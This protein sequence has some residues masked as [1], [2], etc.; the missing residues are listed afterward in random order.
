[1]FKCRYSIHNKQILVDST[2]QQFRQVRSEEDFTPTYGDEGEYYHDLSF[3]A[4]R[5][6][7]PTLSRSARLLVC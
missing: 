2:E 1:M 4:H 6:F 3:V 7:Y 5:D